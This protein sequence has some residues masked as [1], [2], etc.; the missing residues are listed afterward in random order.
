MFVVLKMLL[1]LWTKLLYSDLVFRALGS[2]VSRNRDIVFLKLNTKVRE[3]FYEKKSR[4][5]G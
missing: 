3:H 4:K 5:P 1:V 2:Q